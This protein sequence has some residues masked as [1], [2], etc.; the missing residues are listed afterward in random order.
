MVVY[1]QSIFLVFGAFFICFILVEEDSHFY[2]VAS[3]KFVLV[4]VQS[5]TKINAPRGCTAILLGKCQQS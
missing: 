1:L 2:K 5:P 3:N 4:R